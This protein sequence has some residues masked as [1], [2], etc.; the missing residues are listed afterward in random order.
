[1][2]HKDSIIKDLDYPISEYW[3]TSGSALLMHGVK[4]ML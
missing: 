3:I 2:L 1:M 4:K